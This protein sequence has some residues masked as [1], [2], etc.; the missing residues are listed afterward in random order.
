MLVSCHGL[1]K[2]RLD[3]SAISVFRVFQLQLYRLRTSRTGK[4]IQNSDFSKDTLVLRL[5]CI[6]NHTVGKPN[7]HSGCSLRKCEAFDGL[8]RSAPC[9][10]CLVLLCRRAAVLRVKKKDEDGKQ[11]A[12]DQLDDMLRAATGSPAR[13]VL[14]C[15]NVPPPMQFASC[16]VEPSLLENIPSQKK[17][18]VV[19]I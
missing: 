12:I 2:Q 15:P 14:G 18:G 4:E 9:L 17:L 7:Q 6:S 10:S 13:H 1:S 3:N 8:Q 16:L 11:A 5:R 19:E